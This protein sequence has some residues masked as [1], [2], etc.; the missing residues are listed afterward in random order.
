MPSH[1]SGNLRFAARRSFSQNGPDVD[2][3]EYEAKELFA[4]YGVPVQAGRVAQ[5]VTRPQRSGA[6]VGFPLR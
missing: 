4:E 6:D 5:T 1:A 3:F 2:L